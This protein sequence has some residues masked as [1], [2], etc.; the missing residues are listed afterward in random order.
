MKKSVAIAMMLDFME[1]EM[2]EAMT[3]R[4]FESFEFHAYPDLEKPV[5]AVSD[6]SDPR[7]KSK[8]KAIRRQARGW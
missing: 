5:Q 2:K 3:D 8:S 4:G 1:A 6:L 7:L